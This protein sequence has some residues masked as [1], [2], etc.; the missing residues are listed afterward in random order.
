MSMTSTARTTAC[1]ALLLTSLLSAPLGAQ[2]SGLPVLQNAFANPGL[3]AAIDFGSG[4]G[5]SVYAAAVS[6]G[7]RRFAFSAGLGAFTPDT[8][9]SGPSIGG[10]AS[11]QVMS[12]LRGAM[13]VSVFAGA[14]GGASGDVTL[15]QAPVGAAIG[16]RRAL[17]T[18]RGISVY[19]APIFA[20]HR[21]SD[22]TVSVSR[23]LLRASF[24]VD[25]AITRRL[26]ITVG[27]E[28]GAS[29]DDDEPGPNGNMAGI[30]IGWAFGRQ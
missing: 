20:Y 11:M 25:L 15:F 9:S 18:S 14:G 10:R 23:G 22:D 3:T 4:A 27:G 26:G 8:G 5:S 2:L 24:G 30:A 29:P 21:A 12:F 7:V 28:V 1:R 6:Y 13:G 17:G 16:W 19:A